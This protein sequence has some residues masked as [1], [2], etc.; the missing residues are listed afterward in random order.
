MNKRFLAKAA[1]VL[2]TVLMMTACG[3]APAAVETT[4]PPETTT[5]AA[6]T[7][8]AAPEFPFESAEITIDKMGIG[9]NLGNTFDSIAS[10]EMAGL[11]AEMAWGNPKTTEELIKAV[12]AAGFDSVRIPIT[13]MH[14]FDENNQIDTAWLARVRE[15]TQWVVENDMYALINVHHD[16]QQENGW[17]RPIFTGDK[18]DSM[19]KTF[20]DLWTQIA[21]YFED[22]GGNVLFAGMNEFHEG[23]GNIDPDWLEITDILNQAFID[24]VRA[25][26]GNNAKRVLVFQSYNTT[27]D[28]ALMMKTPDDTAEGLMA[29]EVH[30]YDPWNFAGEGKGSWSNTAEVDARFDR[31][32][33]GFID[34]GIPVILGEYGCVGNEDPSRITY[35]TYVTQAAADRGIV[36]MWWDNGQFGTGADKFALFDRNTAAVI[37]QPALDA[38]MSAK[39]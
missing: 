2:L 34:K 25:T 1:S 37:D 9:W 10:E 12:K 19:V 28:A 3:S 33:T 15:V 22:F 11:D 21:N 26:G 31:L 6:T 24:T 18:R 38:I 27:T 8:A 4:L 14:H 5:V 36:P 20:T 32:K 7:V 23:Y 17:L 13:W 35:I 29:L 30:S 16:G 39:Q